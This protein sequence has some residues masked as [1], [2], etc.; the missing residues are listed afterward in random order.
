M[1]ALS[2]IGCF[3]FAWVVAHVVLGRFLFRDRTK[4]WEQF[5]DMMNE[6]CQTTLLS[7]ASGL[8]G[9]ITTTILFIWWLRR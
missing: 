6:G 7:I 4:P 8:I 5:E 2:F 9:A 3:L 1:F